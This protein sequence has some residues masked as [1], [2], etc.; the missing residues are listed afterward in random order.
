MRLLAA[1]ASDDSLRAKLR[2]DGSDDWNF[3]A[4]M[5]RSPL[6]LGGVLR[7]AAARNREYAL[8]QAS[9]PAIQG[10]R[11][12][13]APDSVTGLSRFA[14]RFGANPNWQLGRLLSD[15]FEDGPARIAPILPRAEALRADPFP[16]RHQGIAWLF[17]EELVARDRGRLRAA[18]LGSQGWEIVAGEILELPHHL[19]WPCPVE[20]DGRLFL[21]PE[22]GEASE[23]ALWECTDFP[24]GWK[25]TKVLLEGRH[26]HDPSLLKHGDHWWLFVSSGG[27]FEHDH[28][29]ELHVFRSSSPLHDSFVPHEGN[30]L[31]VS[32]A[33]S[34][35]AG[36]PFVHEG[37]L[38]RP[39][40]DCRSGYGSGILLQRLEE[41]SLT[42]WR[43]THL[44]R[45]GAP[46]GCRGIHTLNH[47]PEAGWII[48]WQ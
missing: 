20:I 42:T 43:E 15:P 7:S 19:S 36:T 8:S 46:P 12:P 38:I 40:Q 16:L 29:A 11:T 6:H 26:W 25:K 24:F 33:G 3:E 10:C 13:P 45:I 34:R 48:D 22:T 32:V 41:L 18:R 47:L 14:K 23:V 5:P 39:T 17:F 35:P 37:A 28:S 1:W 27:E 4:V 21:L 31:S 2:H 44:N 30:P 9:R